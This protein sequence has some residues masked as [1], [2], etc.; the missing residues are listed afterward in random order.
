MDA[1]DLAESLPGTGGH[2][3]LPLQRLRKVGDRPCPLPA[4]GGVGSSPGAPSR[5]PAH[6]PRRR[7]PP[8]RAAGRGPP[9]AR[10][11]HDVAGCAT[12]TGPRRV[13]GGVRAGR[14]RPDAARRVRARRPQ[15]LPRASACRC[16]SSRPA[17]RRRTRCGPSRL[18][19]DDYVTKPF[20]PEELLARVRAR[21]RRPALEREGRGPGRTLH[22][23]PGGPPR[24]GRTGGRS[25]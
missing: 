22:D 17:T 16:S 3:A 7:R 21:L 11:L 12:A 9:R 5:V 13:A 1:G 24:R 15:A 6:P 20:W 19:A 8:A 4:P 25:T 10:G 23:R 14:A 2:A 18:G